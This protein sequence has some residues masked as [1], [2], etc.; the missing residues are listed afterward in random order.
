[1][2]S[3]LRIQNLAIVEDLEIEFGPGMNVLTGETGAGKSIVLRAMELLMGKRA[4]TDLL[5]SG[6]DQCVVEGLFLLGE[7]TSAGTEDDDNDL[8]DLLNEDELLIRRVLDRSGRG[9][10]TANG[11]LVTAGMLQH[12]APQLLDIT[13]QHQQRTL[14]DSDH[15]RT[16]LDDFGVPRPLRESVAAAFR[17]YAHAKQRL[18]SFLKDQG[19]RQEYFRRISFERDELAAAQLEDGKRARL[20]QELR[21]LASMETLT[22][23]LNRALEIMDTGESNL[24]GQ[25]RALAGIVD[26]LVGIDPALS[27]GA[28]LIES[29]S[30]QIG[31]AKLLLEEYA[32]DLEAEPDRLESLREQVAEIAKLER[33]YGRQEPDLVEY[34][35]RIE[36]EL[37]DL[38]SGAMDETALRKKFDDARAAL[39]V[40]ERELTAAREQAGKKLASTVKAALKP[41]GMKHAEFLVRRQDAPSSASGADAI[42]FHLSANPGEPPQELAKVASGGELS[43]ILLVL[44]TILNERSGAQTQI[45]DE[46]DTGISGAV[47]QIVGEKLRQVSKLAQVIL[48]THSPQIA[49][50]ADRHYCI[51]KSVSGSRTSTS[52]SLL[53]DAERVRH[54]ASMLGGKKVSAHFEQSARE[55]LAHRK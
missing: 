16:V 45:F 23:L 4:S 10:I 24:D 43:R 50:F 1:M 6:A 25:F 22:S 54:I 28:Q 15:H 27:D 37:A 11:R 12:L 42:E 44:K 34:Y 49:A 21:R 32:A 14:L 26:S 55:L 31:E 46:V 2:L 19:E 51:S 35:R 47:A 39:T 52:L 30:V 17:E 48:V 29:A 13:G 3:V 5:R 38:Q 41:L 40:V 18:D 53:D 8:S 36:V 20:E 33:K 9:K 7:K